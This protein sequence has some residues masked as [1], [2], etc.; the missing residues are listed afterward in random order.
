MLSNNHNKENNGKEIEIGGV[1]RIRATSKMELFVIIVN[2]YRL[3]ILMN[4]CIF[5]V[6]RGKGVLDI[7]L[8]KEMF[9]FEGNVLHA[10][11]SASKYRDYIYDRI[12]GNCLSNL[13]VG[14]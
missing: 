14:V 10:E 12:T 4:T 3:T 13:P 8:M 5:D 11:P 1:S 9:L 7:A 2:G 6:G